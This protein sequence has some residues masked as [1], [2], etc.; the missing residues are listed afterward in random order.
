MNLISRNN[1]YTK[2]GEGFVHADCV[3]EGLCMWGV[4]FTGL[5]HV[6]NLDTIN[7]FLICVKD[8]HKNSE[9]GNTKLYLIYN[10]SSPQ[11]LWWTKNVMQEIKSI[12]KEK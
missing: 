10:Y 1:K 12:L 9:D 5:F 8:M 11:K 6:L 7:I 3:C 4:V 2:K